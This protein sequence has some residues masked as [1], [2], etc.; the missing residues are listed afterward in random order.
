MQDCSIPEC[1]YYSL[2]VNESDFGKKAWYLSNVDIKNVNMFCRFR[3]HNHRL[4]VE[5][6]SWTGIDLANRVCLTC[7]V[8]EDEHHF[9]FVC[10]RYEFL[11]TKYLNLSCIHTY[12]VDSFVNLFNTRDVK[13]CNNLC[14]FIRKSLVQHR[15]D[16]N[17]HNIV[18]TT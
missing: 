17:T 7:N 3:L 13:L 6:G 1:K 2:L 18:D 5:E 15:E 11:R 10:P 14:I 12:T 16:V 4:A 8:L 9:I